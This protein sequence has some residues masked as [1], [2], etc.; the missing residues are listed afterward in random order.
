MFPRPFY[1][2][3]VFEC[4]L[5]LPL[6]APLKLHS[7]LHKTT[8]CRYLPSPKILRQNPKETTKVTLTSHQLLEFLRFRPYKVKHLQSQCNKGIYVTHFCLN[9]E[10]QKF[11]SICTLK[12]NI[13]LIDIFGYNPLIEITREGLSPSLNFSL[14]SS[15][16]LTLY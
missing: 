10:Q 4:P 2:L 15:S 6:S 11:V 5:D 9:F 3:V 13:D 8:I 14:C 16:M 12:A 7:F 1:H